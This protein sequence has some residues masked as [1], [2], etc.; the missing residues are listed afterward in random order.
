VRKNEHIYDI[1]LNYFLFPFSPKPESNKPKKLSRSLSFCSLFTLSNK[2]GKLKIS[3]FGSNS[4][5]NKGMENTEFLSSKENLDYLPGNSRESFNGRVLEDI[6]EADSAMKRLSIV[7]NEI[8]QFEREFVIPMTKSMSS[9]NIS[10]TSK[11]RRQKVLQPK[12][13]SKYYSTNTLGSKRFHSSSDSVISEYDSGAYSR[14]STPDFSLMSSITDVSEPLVSPSLVM[15]YNAQKVDNIDGSDNKPKVSPNIRMDEKLL[16]NPSLVGRCRPATFTEVVFANNFRTKF[17][18]FSKDSSRDSQS[19]AQDKMFSS[20]PK[21]NK[22]PVLSKS[23][24]LLWTKTPTVLKR[25]TTSVGFSLS[26]PV[27][28]AT[29]TVKCSVNCQS[30]VTVNGLCYHQ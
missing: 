11:Q 7:V 3:K 4:S 20:T 13:M 14:E 18:R 28:M 15:S 23:Q 25:S 17:E 6:D 27:S 21:L 5:L 16:E 8:E 10:E 24:S 19:V 26:A 29:R 12:R 1:S 30:E 2:R 9:S 22:R